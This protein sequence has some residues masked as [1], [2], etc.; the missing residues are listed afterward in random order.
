MEVSEILGNASQIIE[1]HARELF[2]LNSDLSEGRLRICLKC[3]LYLDQFGGICNNGLFYNPKTGDV[4]EKKKDGYYKGCGCRLR[5]KTTL[6]NEH[7][8]AGKW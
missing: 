5:A 7:C 2:G 3:P 1:G 8:P 4:S 6:K